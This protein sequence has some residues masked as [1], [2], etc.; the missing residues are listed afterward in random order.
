[1][2][3]TLD[4]TF[5]AD[6]RAVDP[7]RG[8]ALVREIISL[9][10]EHT[11]PLLDKLVV[12]IATRDVL[13]RRITLHRLKGSSSTIGARQFAQLCDQLSLRLHADPGA[14]VAQDLRALRREYTRLTAMLQDVRGW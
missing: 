7:A 10:L 11:A 12:S 3:P 2:L 5:L 9:F 8:S 4:P 13:P 1:M 6:L 14:D